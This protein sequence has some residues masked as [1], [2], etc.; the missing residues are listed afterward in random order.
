[1]FTLNSDNDQSKN[2]LSL[3]QG[4]HFFYPTKFP[5]FSL[6]SYEFSL[7]FL[8]FHQNILVKKTYLFF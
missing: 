7:I 8:S 3:S 6:I 2:S 5:D 4:S 1:M